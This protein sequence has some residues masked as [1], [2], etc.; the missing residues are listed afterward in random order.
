MRN[1]L[2]NKAV[3]IMLRIVKFI[4]YILLIC[5]VFIVIMQR[6][7]GNTIAIGGIRMFNVVSESMAPD[8]TKGDILIVKETD[9]KKI[10]VGQDIAYQGEEGQVAGKIVTHRVVNIETENNELKFHTK[11]ISNMIE[12]PEVK[13]NQIFGVV[14]YKMFF[15][16]IINKLMYN[17]YFFYFIIIVPTGIIIFLEIKN[18]R[19]KLREDDCDE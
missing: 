8:Y 2:D 16:S 13:E 15:L 1:L 12:D 10:K 5:I 6:V 17:I 11:G 9:A 19:E 3:R 14:V 7:S 18:R 4:I